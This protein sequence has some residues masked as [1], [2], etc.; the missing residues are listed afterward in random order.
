[1]KEN[2]VCMGRGRVAALVIADLLPLAVMIPGT[3]TLF[4]GMLPTPFYLI[5]VFVLPLLAM[6]LNFA[7]VRSGLGWLGR[8]LLIVVV[9][10]V[11]AFLE[12]G[13]LLGLHA[14]METYAGEDALAQYASS[15]AAD[16]DGFPSVDALGD[17]ES[18]EY[19]FY[20]SEY[21]IFFDVETHALRCR[22][23]AGEYLRQAAALE[24]RYAFEPDAEVAL[25]EFRFRMLALESSEDYVYPKY[26]MF[27]AQNDA[28]GE[29]V[30]LYC[31]DDDLDYIESMED[32]IRG[33]L[34]W[35]WIR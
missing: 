22:Y 26:L 17:Y 5:Q 19:C 2:S 23:D 21:G 28:A 30:Y 1:M 14:Y 3:A 33:N 7:V 35:K 16:V 27:V 31:D 20:T 32:Y 11:C 29:I 4:T 9:L 8:A 25:D 10:G 34:G 6:L 13:A 24:E 15:D 18:V 12:I